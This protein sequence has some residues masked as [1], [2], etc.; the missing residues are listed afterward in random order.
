MNR[1]WILGFLA[2]ATIQ[3]AV[4]DDFEDGTTQNW[5]VGLLGAPSP[6]P[7]VNVTDG[8]P[9]GAGD[10]YMQLTSIGGA[11]AGSRLVAINLSQWAG[12]YTSLGFTSISMDL[13]NLGDTDLSIRL[14]LENPMGAPPTDDAVTDSILLPAGGDWTHATFDVSAAGLTALNGSVATLLSNVTALRIMHSPAAGFPPPAIAAVLGVDNITAI[15]EPSTILLSALGLGA[16]L[17]KAYRR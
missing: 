10:N 12:N 7:P 2:A 14:Y 15:P 13:R 8:G 17:L 11:G 9:L 1:I 5:V 6:V 3:G 4:I 16:L